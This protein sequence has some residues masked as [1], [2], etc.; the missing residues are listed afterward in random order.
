MASQSAD[1]W[2][3]RRR[4]IRPILTGLAIVAAVGVTVGPV[5]A[6]LASL[7]WLGNRVLPGRHI[8]ANAAV[9]ALIA[10]PVVWFAGS[11]LPLVPPAARVQDNIWA[12]QTAGLAVWLLFF[13]TWLERTPE[14][15]SWNERP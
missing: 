12:H 7:L 11:S 15:R 1:L 8:L 2:E 9:V 6:V 14:D 13:A 3:R 4:A 10:V 5:P